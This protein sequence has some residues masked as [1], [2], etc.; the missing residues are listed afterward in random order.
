[1][2]AIEPTAAVFVA[3][4]PTIDLRDFRGDVDLS[5]NNASSLTTAI[6]QAQAAGASGNTGAVIYHPGGNVVTEGIVSFPRNGTTPNTVVGMIGG[7]Q[8]TA[9]ITGS[10][11]AFIDRGV[12]EWA[13]STSKI[14]YPRF[15][16]LRIVVPNV[17]GAK[18]IYLKRNA[19]S[20]T[21]DAAA[22]AEGMSEGVFRNLEFVGNTDY[23]P[24]FF[25]VETCARAC[26]FANIVGQVTNGASQ[27]YPVRMFRFPQAFTDATIPTEGNDSVG[28][29]E[30]EFNGI[31]TVL[32]STGWSLFFDGRGVANKFRRIFCNGARSG[33]NENGFHLVNSVRNHIDGYSNEGNAD[34]QLK[35]TR[36]HG[37]TFINIGTPSSRPSDAAWVA[38]TAYALGARVVSTAMK[39][40]ASVATANL[41]FTCTTAGTSGASEPT[42]G[43]TPGGT[44]NDGTV[45]WTA[46]TNPA[47]SDSISL[48]ASCRNVFHKRWTHPGAR[49]ASYGLVRTIRGDADSHDNQ[50]RDFDLR[51][52]VQDSTVD[53]SSDAADEITFAGNRN[54]AEG[55]A[56]QAFNNYQLPYRIGAPRGFLD[57]SA[58][59]N[60]GSLADGAGETTTVTVTGA[61]LGDFAE[62]SFSNN[63]S[64]ISVTAWVS[65][66][67][68]VSVR[69]QNESGGTLD[70]SSGTLRVRVR[71]R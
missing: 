51:I 1:M 30:C 8:R 67:D 56:L 68:T 19:A 37:N 4:R 25:D 40:A 41:Y 33:H 36:S 62:W 70:L 60:P 28:A 23:H 69:F 65:A 9:T 53:G 39:N 71:K 6:A 43:T 17:A 58:T 50:F 13:A 48:V 45:V 32:V 15:E 52:V 59:F 3:G 66:T 29:Y 47:V 22:L 42:W 63:V 46:S 7:G 31:W 49:T 11:N 14:W 55:I 21:T 64:G 27:T 12:I 35:L 54:Y 10:G 38:N 44:T 24:V 26:E 61:A 18:A 5:G 16:N 20:I 57:G 2:A 34:T